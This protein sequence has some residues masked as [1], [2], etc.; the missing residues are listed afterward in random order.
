MLIF[1]L[2]GNLASLSILENKYCLRCKLPADQRSRIQGYSERDQ[3]V[4]S[5]RAVID[6]YPRTEVGGMAMLDILR[7]YGGS[8]DAVSMNAAYKSLI[9]SLPFTEYE[10]DAHMYLGLL[11]LQRKGAPEQAMRYFA[12]IPDPRKQPRK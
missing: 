10:M 3:I 2:D 11:W 4:N 12:S 7:L 9:E 1:F 6:R 8:D 5:Y